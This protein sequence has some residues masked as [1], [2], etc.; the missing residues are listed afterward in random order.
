[1]TL[2]YPGHPLG[3]PGGPKAPRCSRNPKKEL[4]P[5]NL[6]PH[7]ETFWVKNSEKLVFGVF[8]GGS[9][10]QHF[11]PPVWRSFWCVFGRFFGG[12]LVSFCVRFRWKCK[13]GKVCLDCTGVDG[14]HVRPCTGRAVC[15]LFFMFLACF[16]CSVAVH[17]FSIDFGV[18]L[19]GVLSTFLLNF[20]QTLGFGVVFG[21]CRF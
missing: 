7:F 8:F 10:F 16:V 18:I 9:F 6:G 5:L 11:F 15:M 14:L 3:G 17:R 19:G 21:G 1:M 4:F 13:T 2:G 12:V 20:G